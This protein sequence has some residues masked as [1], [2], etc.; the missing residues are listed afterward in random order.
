MH[1]I[2]HIIYFKYLIYAQAYILLTS[3]GK[4]V[5][6]TDKKKLASNSVQF[7][8]PLKF[9]RSIK[10]IADS[11]TLEAVPSKFN[12]ANDYT[13]LPCDSLPLLDFSSLISGDPHQR[14]KTVQDLSEACRVWG[15]FIV[16]LLHFR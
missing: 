11:S 10:A 5:H 7:H 12:I 6:I 13:A 15:F 1:S 4:L 2:C 14:T 9:D 16:K 3:N 8:Q